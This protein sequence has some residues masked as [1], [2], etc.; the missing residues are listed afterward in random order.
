MIAHT[1]TL[2]AA[3]ALVATILAFC[4]LLVGQ[5]NRRDN[6]LLTGYGLLAHALAYVCYTLYG[7][8]PLWISYG[9][10]NSLLSLA[11]AFYS[12][13]LFRV[14]E[15][16]VPWRSIFVI[17]FFMLAGLMLLLDTLEPRM[18]LATL[19]LMLQC[20]LILCWARR[21]AEHQ[22]RAHLL[23][24]IGAL[25]SLV[26]LGMRV[27]A[28]VFG[29][30]AEMRYDTSNLKQT[31]SV[32]IGTV[33]VMMYAIGLVL[34]AKERSESRLQHLALRDV[35][36]GTYNRRAILERFAVELERARDEQSELAVA[37]IDIDHFKRIND[38]HGHLAGDEVLCHCVRQLQ[39]RLRQGDSL[40]RYG[41][42]EFL[43]LLP[44]TDR[45]GALGALQGLRE[46]IARSP[47][48]FAGGDIELR[49]S[50]GLWCGVPGPHHS[51]ASL[52]AQAD[53]ALYQAKAGGRDAV[54]MA[55]LLG[56]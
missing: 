25:I 15:Q 39:Q 40:G 11:L 6:L 44:R 12:A 56:G 49:F 3:V 36:T 35:L 13:S 7:H 29:E 31:I 17:P 41:G 14:R 16:R 33:T 48:R 53:A 23:L 9:L 54:R 43:L 8:A 46:A 28:V 55:A 38:L 2:F 27:L 19:V 37:M 22:G 24:M 21:R 18:L 47:A 1:P 52:I 30:A 50:V 42:E 4:L 34:M 51:I 32:S 5:L 45:E 26:G 20:S 10:G